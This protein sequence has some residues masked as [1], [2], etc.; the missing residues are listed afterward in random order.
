MKNI[1][2]VFKNLTK[3][4]RAYAQELIPCSDGTYADP[5]IGCVSAPASVVNPDSSIVDLILQIASTL[6]GIVAGVAVV[7]LIIG[8]I[9]YA[10]SIG[11]DEKIQKAKRL[12][13]WSVTGLVIAL[14]ARTLAQFVL[15]SIV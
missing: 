14:L 1:I 15:S 5:S 8:G 7:T 12:I 10:I 6:M 13:F 4:D 11:S 2:N 3:L 9:M